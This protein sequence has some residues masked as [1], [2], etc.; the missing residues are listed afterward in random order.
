M[1]KQIKE[2]TKTRCDTR[3]TLAIPNSEKD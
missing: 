1:N 2:Q 3:N